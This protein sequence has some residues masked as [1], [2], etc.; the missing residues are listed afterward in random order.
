MSF[1]CE[2]CKGCFDDSAKLLDSDNHAFCCTGCKNVYAFLR[3]NDLGEFYSR[4]GKSSHIKAQTSEISE[5]SAK[6]IFSNFVK[7]NGDICTI[8]LVIEGIHCSA[9]IWLNEKALSASD[10]VLEADIN[11]ATNKA[12]IVWDNSQISLHQILNKI[13]A[14][15]YNPLPYDPARAS[16]R[17]EHSR[18]SAYIKMIVGLACTMNIMW[19]A[20]ALYGGYFSGMSQQIKDIL[21]FGEFV[22]ASPVL[23]YTGSAFFSA[24]YLSLK[25][26]RVSMDLSVAVGASIAYIYSVYAMLSKQDEVY[27]DSVAM[28]ITFVYVGK[29]FETIS[30]KRAVDSLDSLSSLLVNEV[31]ARRSSRGEFALIN[32]RE[33]QKGDEIMLRSGERVAID[34]VVLSGAASVDNSS[35]N[36]ESLPVL[37]SK[38]DAINSGALCVD[39]SVIYMASKDYEHSLL[40]RL[41]C[42]L[43]D[44]SFK[45]P[46]IEALANSIA[47]RFSL[48]I[49]MLALGTFI[50]YLFSGASA[51]KAIMVAISVLIIACPCALSL[52]TPVA[53]LVGLATALKKGIIFRQ[54]NIIERLAKCKIIAFDK[55]GTLS[56]ARLVIKNQHELAPFDKSLLFCLVASST[57]PISVAIARCFKHEKPIKLKDIQ[58]HAGKGVKASYNNDILLG[59][60]AS[61]MRE[62]NV[63]LSALKMQSSTNS[64]YYFAINKSLVAH[65]E[66]EDELRDDAKNVIKQL[67]KLGY[68]I[69][70]LSGDKEQV[71][72]NV[73]ARLGIDEFYGELDPINKA[74][75][76]KE[77]QSKAPTLMIGDGINDIAALKSASVSICMGSGASVSIENSDVVLLRGDLSSLLLALRLSARTYRT[78]KQNL[79]FSL[80]YNA[81][82]IPLAMAGFIIPLFAAISMSA[83]SIVVVL[84]S[85]KIK[86]VK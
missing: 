74:D 14:I 72:S 73:S 35:I 81:L 67:K 21:H 10:G 20:V 6:A 26:R 37:L 22:L 65:F 61:F 9:C 48:I 16:S 29:F 71:A 53:N 57:H 18:R 23:F 13:I 85:L 59:G 78:I 31:Y 54:A 15:G 42:L 49:L 3:S 82:T 25:Q 1:I 7:Q 56:K 2:H 17:A 40:N 55:T 41:I 30:K 27:F 80:F 44:A 58:N 24:A 77:L 79:G 39:G 50:F 75:K 47:S 66:L 33:I 28:I 86:G 84:N 12:R 69:V 38:D 52:A 64:E 34:G 4:L 19:V 8:Y 43:E 60:S 68:K 45:K 70:M 36:G 32:V 63:D 11:A 51:S 76:I 5:Q 83:S 46:R 62:N